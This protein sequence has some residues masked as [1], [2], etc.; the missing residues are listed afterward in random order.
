MANYSRVEVINEILRVGVIPVFYNS[1][2]DMAKSI[3]EAC[4]AAG[5]RVIEFTN[6]GDN[7]YRV[8]SD[9]VLHFAKVDPSVILG[10]GSVLDPATGGIYISSGANFVVGS[11]LNPDL[12]RVCNRWKV[13]YSPGC[14]SASEISQAEELGV[15]IVKI[16][17]GDSVGGPRFVKSILGPTPWTRI[18]PTGGVE[19]TSES[20]EAWF[21][22]GVAAVGI[23]S[24]LVRKEWVK[25]GKFDKITELGQKLIGWARLARG[26]SPFIDIEHIGLYGHDHVTGQQIVDWYQKLFGFN[27][28][29]SRSSIFVGGA[30]PGSIE[31]SKDDKK[32]CCHIAVR[33]ADFYKAMDHLRSLGVE[34]DE[35][36][37]KP[38]LKSVFLKETDPVGNLVHLIW[39]G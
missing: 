15:E 33:V 1:D 7:A 29:E 13:S 18:M 14:G 38:G 5:L 8:F 9:L 35:P 11:V 34:M 20:I 26:N 25:E 27:L 2:F 21:K 30:R 22:A 23:G 28:E 31:V 19:A 16:F 24:N 3:I 36:K 12:A 32:D 17:P 4:V 10:V 39:R 6:R 37:V